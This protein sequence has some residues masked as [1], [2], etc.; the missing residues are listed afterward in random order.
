MP[1]GIMIGA[2]K[3]DIIILLGVGISLT[4]IVSVL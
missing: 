3:G 4:G 1:F 2:G